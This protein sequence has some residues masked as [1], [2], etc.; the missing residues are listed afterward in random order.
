VSDFECPTLNRGDIVVLDN[1]GSHKGDKVRQLIEAAGA[2]LRYL[3]KYSPDL[4]PIENA[5]AKLKR[6]LSGRPQSAQPK[7]SG[8]APANSSG[9]SPRRNA[10]TTSTPQDI[11]PNMTEFC[12]SFSIID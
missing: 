2:R 5:F 1:L 9:T 8:S 3:R 11:C 12:S 6:L 4:N 7:P 10:P